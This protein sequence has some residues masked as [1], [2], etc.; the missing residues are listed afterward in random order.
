MAQQASP[1]GR[2]ENVVEL[3]QALLR[4]PRADETLAFL[5]NVL[6][7]MG[8][9]TEILEFFGTP[10]LYAIRRAEAEASQTLGFLGHAD[11]VPEGDGWAVPPFGGL[12]REGAVWGRGA[13]D[14]KGGIACFLSALT[15]LLTQSVP[16]PRLEILIS[17]DEEGTAQGGVPAVLKALQEQGRPLKWDFALVG[18]PTTHEHVGDIIKIGS[19][20]SMNVHA[21][22][23]GISGHVAYSDYCTNPVPELM[24][25]LNDAAQLI[26]HEQDGG[27][28]DGP[29]EPTQMQI[30]KLAAGGDAV[31]VVPGIAE[32]RFNIRYAPPSTPEDLISKLEALRRRLDHASAIRLEFRNEGNIVQSPSS[33]AHEL[34]SQA[35]FDVVGQRPCKTA[36]GATSDTR[37]FPPNI[38][39]AELGLRVQEA[40]QTNE[41]VPIKDLETLTEIYKTFIQLFAHAAE[42][43]SL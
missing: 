42:G 32:A 13:V 38:P 7:S 35:V 21:T 3:T 6:E 4:K 30:T 23:H 15:Q 11:V 28:G 12:L 19:R 36:R 25:F 33:Y 9:E 10:N 2:L 17:G 16:L 39:F 14:M 43:K 20:G 5:K 34:L 41:K 8:F 40:H 31:N 22:A 1:I 26:A 37:F 29:F 18:E 27:Q 24:A